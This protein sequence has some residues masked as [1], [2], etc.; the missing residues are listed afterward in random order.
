MTNATTFDRSDFYYE[1]KVVAS[2]LK[3]CG[4]GEFVFS[5]IFSQRHATIDEIEREVR[6]VQVAFCSG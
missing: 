4:V 1:P 3:R 2:V 5:S 6:E